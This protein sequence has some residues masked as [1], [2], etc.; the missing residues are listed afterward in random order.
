MREIKFRAWDKE[1]SRMILPNCLTEIEWNSHDIP[2][3]VEYNDGDGL[4]HTN[5]FELMQYT[6]LKDKNG[7]EIFE[8]DIVTDGTINKA[9][10]IW[11]KY[12]WN[13]QEYYNTSYDY[14]SEAFSEGM[15]FEVIGNTY[16]NSELLSSTETK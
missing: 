4:M 11:D 14:P 16:Q 2:D 5:N 9:P 13:I 12:R 10:V 3:A 8:G 15:P 1:K 6:G 7:V